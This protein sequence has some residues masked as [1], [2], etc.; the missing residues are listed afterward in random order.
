L[1]QQQAQQA[2]LASIQNAYQPKITE[3]DNQINAL[4]RQLDCLA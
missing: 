3:D 1:P 4:N 2:Q